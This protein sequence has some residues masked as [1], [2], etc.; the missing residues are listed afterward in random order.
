MTNNK[1]QAIKAY[2]KLNPDFD[3]Q[4]LTSH[5]LRIKS[6]KEQTDLLIEASKDKIKD[7]IAA[8]SY[9]EAEIVAE[10][11]LKI[12]NDFKL[13]QLLAILKMYLGKMP[14]AKK[15]CLENI[16]KYK[17]AEDYNN[18]SLVERSLRNFSA[19][20]SAGKKAY[21]KK[22]NSASIAAN[23]AITAMV[24]NKPKEAFVAIEKALAIDS[25]CS[26]FYANK[27][28]MLCDM[29]KYEEAEPIF[30]KCIS[31]NPR[32][33]QI[34]MD[35]FYCLSNQKKYK[36][37]WPYY[38]SRYGKIK[39]LMQNIKVL[40]KP[41]MYFKKPFYDEKICIIP[42]QGAGDSIMFLR[43][44][45]EFQ[46]IAPNSYFYCNDNTYEFA[47][48]LPINIS[49]K[50]HD[51]SSHVMGI[52]SLPFH[53]GVSNIPPP[54]SPI[55]HSPVKHEKLKIGICWAGS[56]F[57]PMDWSRSTYLKWWEPFLLDKNMEIYSFMKD[58]RPRLYTNTKEEINYSEGF[59]NYKINDLSAN[60]TSAY[61]TALEF[62]KIDVL[63]TVDSF[64]AHLAGTC[65]VPVYLLVSDKHDWRWGP[66]QR[67]SE[68]YPTIKIYRRKKSKSFQE[69]IENVHQ[70]IKGGI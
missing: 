60:F 1:I 32:E 70:N 7:L 61:A 36:K 43:F 66:R 12:K 10:Q 57:H 47:K 46:K 24:C 52:M 27:A 55:V 34:Y 62:N 53:L 69:I 20:Y 9:I 8:Q 42:E 22:P 58:R 31:L 16:K 54:I 56:A 30:E 33:N 41:V 40:G 2:V 38:E 63:V 68:W 15:L 65:G 18:L 4:I 14:E 39:E 37:A 17:L 23:F 26:M 11:A 5:K 13:K 51:D 49:D 64:V 45:P 48:K 28:S 3:V 44:L 67:H 50:F 21:K 25:N 6:K 19:S 29:K 59:E 35:Y